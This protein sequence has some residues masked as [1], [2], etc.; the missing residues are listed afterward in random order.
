M[1]NNKSNKF[2]WHNGIS[3]ESAYPRAAKLVERLRS[4][5]G[6]DDMGCRIVY[7]YDGMTSTGMRAS[8]PPTGLR[9]DLW[10][11]QPRR[12]SGVKY[13]ETIQ[14]RNSQDY[15]TDQCASLETEIMETLGKD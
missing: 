8:E 13:C 12:P 5:L 3:V 1:T 7:Q 9:I 11:V 6:V 2:R 15:T 14:L 4:R 10:L